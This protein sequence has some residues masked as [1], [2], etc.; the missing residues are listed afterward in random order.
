MI[1]AGLF[2]GN[3][4][5][6]ALKARGEIDNAGIA[7]VPRRFSAEVPRLIVDVLAPIGAVVIMKGDGF[8]PPLGIGCAIAIGRRTGNAIQ[9]IEEDTYSGRAIVETRMDD[10]P[11]LIFGPIRAIRSTSARSGSRF[12]R[13]I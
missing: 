13:S 8:D 12:R 7:P 5:K 10:L 9:I 4:E 3:I 1:E 6:P 11:A 2:A